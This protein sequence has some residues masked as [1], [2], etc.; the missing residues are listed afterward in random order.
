MPIATRNGLALHLQELGAGPPVVM[1]HGLLLASL[2]TWY[3]T[4]APALARTHH[5][6]LYDLRGHGLSERA[7]EG[8]DTRTMAR[9]LE[10]VASS[11][12]RQP[13][14]LVGHSYGAVIAL[15][16]A[17]D[18]PDQ[19]NKLVLVEAPLPPSQIDEL[20]IFLGMGRGAIADALP[21][22][23]GRSG[24]LAAKL[25]AQI[26]FLSTETTLFDD[27]RREADVDDAE[28]ATLRP[29]LLC[30]YGTRSS[31]RSVG[32]RLARVVPRAKLVE[33]VGGHSLPAEAPAE[34]TRAIT[35]FVHG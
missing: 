9:D 8:Y 33:L 10:A 11:F 24:R 23:L 2:A 21:A 5:V 29:P 15:R 25:T 34:V 4:A 13:F 19:V 7:R 6:A 35:E 14:T 17:L 30:V 16:F 22:W 26:R 28:L 32:Q 1:V 20:D 27:L 12:T 31:V 3:F 18:H